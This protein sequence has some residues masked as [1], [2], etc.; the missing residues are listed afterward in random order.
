MI[1][2]TKPWTSC[3]Q[4]DLG[5]VTAQA[6]R[7]RDVTPLNEDVEAKTLPVAPKLGNAKPSTRETSD[8]V[9][10]KSVS[11]QPETMPWTQHQ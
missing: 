4:C 9:P 3:A 5:H 6:G 10:M 2:V 7:A 11:M 8:T 1:S